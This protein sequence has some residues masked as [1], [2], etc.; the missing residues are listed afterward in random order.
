VT[1][2][3]SQFKPVEDDSAPVDW[4]KFTPVD[5]PSVTDQV[6][7]SLRRA[8][9]GTANTLALALSGANRVVN[10]LEPDAIREANEG[11]L[12]GGA[13]SFNDWVQE[14]A[15]AAP[16]T[17]AGKIAEAVGGFVG[18]LPT[19]GLNNIGDQAT[20][21]L[22][23]GG[24]LPDAYKALSLGTGQTLASMGIGGLGR[25]FLQRALLQTPANVALGAGSR[26]LQGGEV[27]DPYAIGADVG[28]SIAG[29]GMVPSESPAQR[30]AARTQAV[31]DT[32]GQRAG[33]ET[34]PDPVTNVADAVTRRLTGQEP[35][36]P[37]PP[38]EALNPASVPE[39]SP[40]QV[41]AAATPLHE[42]FAAATP[43]QRADFIA[44]MRDM[45]DTAIPGEQG[46]REAIPS[47]VAP[48]GDRVEPVP[49]ADNAEGQ[50]QVAEPIAEAVR[51]T[52]P[53]DELA[54][55]ATATRTLP[56]RG[57][58]NPLADVGGEP[59]PEGRGQGESVGEPGTA[60]IPEGAVRAVEAERPAADEAVPFRRAEPEGDNHES[61]ASGR[62]EA[63]NE[64]GEKQVA[65]LEKN[66]VQFQ[67]REDLNNTPLADTTG[68]LSSQDKGSVRGYSQDGS[69]TVVPEN[70]PKGRIVPVLAHEAIHSN[71]R[72][73]LGDNG[74]ERLGNYLRTLAGKKDAD[75][76]LAHPVLAEAQD[77]IHPNTKPGAVNEELIGHSA[78]YVMS[79]P[80][81]ADSVWGKIKDRV[82]NGLDKMGLPADWAKSNE[83]L[84]KDLALSN[85]QHLAEGPGLTFQT[86]AGRVATPRKDEQT[87]AEAKPVAEPPKPTSEPVKPQE[88]SENLVGTKN[89]MREESQQVRGKEPVQAEGKRSVQN[90]EGTARERIAKD[91]GIGQRLTEELADKG[92]PLTAEEQNIMALHAVHLEN[93]RDEAVNRALEA[94]KSGDERGHMAALADLQRVDHAFNQYEQANR[95]AGYEWAQAGIARQQTF[96]REGLRT[97][98]TRYIQ[99]LSGKERLSAGV[100]ERIAEL[101]TRLAEAEKKL[102]QRA[103]G[104]KPAE[105][106]ADL[107][108]KLLDIAKRL[109][110][111]P[112]TMSRD[113]KFSRADD[114]RSLIKQ[115]ARELAGDK[116][117]IATI[118]GDIGEATGL[119]R[120]QI[121]SIL[122]G[123]AQRNVT[124]QKQLQKQINEK[125]GRI[126]SGDFEKAKRE[127]IVYNEETRKLQIERDK[128]QRELESM[129]AKQRRAS[130]SLPVKTMDIA[131]NLHMGAILSSL[132]VYPKLAYAVVGTNLSKVVEGAV[133]SF[134]RHIPGL[135]KIAEQA[136]RHG[137]GLNFQAELQAI[138]GHGKAFKGALEQLR[139]GQSNLDAQFGTK[140]HH[141]GEFTDFMGDL[142]SSFKQGEYREGFRTLTSIPGR[143]HAMVKEFASQPEFYRSYTLRGNALRDS[144]VKQGMSDADVVEYMTRPSTE[145][146]LGAKAYADALEAK[147]QGKNAIADKINNFLM[148]LER[149]GSGEK[150]LAFAFKSIFPIRKI[151][152]NIAKEATSYTVGLP[153]ALLEM[154]KEITPERADYI[155]KNINKQGVGIGLAAIGYLL[156]PGVLG[157]LTKDKKP[158][159]DAEGKDIRA[160]TGRFGGFDL[161]TEAFHGAPTQ[162]VQAGAGFR[163]VFESYYGKEKDSI[164]AGLH[165]LADNAVAM[166]R[167]DVPYI[168]Q[169][170]RWMETADKAQKYHHRS[171]LAENM[172]NQL[173]SMVVPLAVQQYAAAHDPHQGFRNPR[174]I[175][176]DVKMGVPGLREQV[177]KGPLYKR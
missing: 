59:A 72:N 13:K 162:I 171:G 19:F 39:R 93:A 5:E 73:I 56:D 88:A 166:A 128:V 36:Q 82:L 97:K 118:H 114:I 101:T 41:G 8:A 86:A 16:T 127:P 164:D 144:L 150:A 3:W 146:M 99:A 96:T 140:E 130:E 63:V 74:V 129:A 17:P 102:A 103:S 168:D 123:D 116:D 65:K 28:G 110:A 104:R 4:S 113:A 26:A 64:L 66:G 98:W 135:S 141:T 173:R 132:H 84:V 163:R 53:A 34:P 80:D 27:F 75:G 25:N 94:Q 50:T 52:I 145:A 92:R 54:T 60:E 169:P 90:V 78:E 136:P 148:Q 44:R 23:D 107:R 149:G 100:Q 37:P 7:G 12:F 21:K 1:V 58:P 95:N 35:V 174:N 10:P 131:H 160:N 15:P 170:A 61:A 46:G 43:E 40:P 29:A 175:V 49:A 85:L 167:L 32:L 159:K 124:R 76:A 177:P 115:M 126:E 14:N 156:G 120:E 55:S 105:K 81:V 176:E 9:S 89:A 117:A 119:S 165:A 22:N 139:Y 87:Q 83:R 155:M 11:Q 143:T 30:A 154:R 112:A 42:A 153:K 106:Y 158:E 70:T 18:N 122:S 138:K 161:G 157:G 62:A 69:A 137:Q 51:S 151:P 172:G 91:P 38:Q 121:A 24:N 71:L 20:Q 67:S 133:G 68:E 108:A 57:V 6:A 47:D 152:L 2:D 31:A 33:T 125:R 142:A 48:S 45:I 147:M 109:E 79:H 134:A 111:Q 77:A